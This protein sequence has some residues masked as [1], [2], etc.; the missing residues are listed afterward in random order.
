MGNPGEII[1]LRDK[2]DKLNMQV[3]ILQNP[4][5]IIALARPFCLF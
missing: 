2:V 1:F 4:P 3:Y 5:F